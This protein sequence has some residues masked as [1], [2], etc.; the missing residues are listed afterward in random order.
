MIQNIVKFL[1][2]FLV[3]ALLINCPKKKE[4]DNTALLALLALSSGGASCE[5]TLLGTSIGSVPLT[6]AGSG[7]LVNVGTRIIGS[8]TVAVISAKSITSGQKIVVNGGISTPTIFKQS[9]CPLDS[10]RNVATVT[11]DYTL[12]STASARE[13]TINTA[14]DYLIF[15]NT[16]TATSTIQAGVF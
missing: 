3:A 9:N 5:V 4:E 13:F 7:R 15:V 14:G 10:S 12:N 6:T 16:T 2:L 8:N 1:G 11:T